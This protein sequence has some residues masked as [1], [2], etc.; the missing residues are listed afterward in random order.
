ME[1]QEYWSYSKEYGRK[2]SRD[3]CLKR[4]HNIFKQYK[5][6]LFI[7]LISHIATNF[8][9][10]NDGE[11]INN[12]QSK[13]FGINI[14][15]PLIHRSALNVLFQLIL[16]YRDFSESDNSLTIKKENLAELFLLINEFWDIEYDEVNKNINYSETQKLIFHGIKLF[17]GI[18]N[19]EDVQAKLFY[20]RRLYD[21]IHNNSKFINEIKIFEKSFNISFDYYREILSCLSEIRNT[22]EIYNILIEKF[23]IDINDI[24]KKWNN[25]IPK[26]PIPFDFKFLIDYPIIKTEKNK[27]VLNAYFLFLAIIMKCYYILCNENVTPKFR[28]NVTKYVLEDIVKNFLSETFI[29]ENIK[30]L[31]LTYDSNK[32]YADWGMIYDDIIFL[33]EIKSGTIPVEKK[34]GKDIDAFYKELSK[35]YIE[36]QGINQ[37]IKS[38]IEIEKNYD[39][40]CKRCN[41][42][43]KK[44]IILPVLLLYDDI[45]EIT[46]IN[47]YMRQKYIELIGRKKFYPKNFILSANNAIIT[48]TD[49]FV[50]SKKTFEN[51]EERIKKLIG[52]Y[53]YR[54]P[55]RMFLEEKEISQ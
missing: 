25:R 41:I 43:K 24:E 32:E 15:R 7:H 8:G 53:R 17:Y 14:K 54:L 1:Y 48:F 35:K 44:Y 12:I 38:L 29:G 37:Q 19:G 3:E 11:M 20:F 47:D 51:P 50:F 34:Y 10:D 4:I 36:E 22:K 31:I 39:S 40:F 42:E 52:Y 23:A 21:E 6:E 2:L 55:F 28:Q 9:V 33:F 26:I 13:L 27:Y 18:V 45:F 16:E 30:N 5:R 49:L 46:G